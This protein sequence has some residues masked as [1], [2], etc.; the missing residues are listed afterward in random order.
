MSFTLRDKDFIKAKDIFFQVL[1]Y[2]HPNDKVVAIPRYRIASFP[3]IWRNHQYYARIF[4]TYSSSELKKI[5]EKIKEFFKYDPLLD[6]TLPLID[7]KDIKEIYLTNK[8]KNYIKKY[9]SLVNRFIELLEIFKENINLIYDDFGLT[10]S[11]LIGIHNPIYS[12]I[13]IV[14]YGFKNTDKIKEFVVSSEEIIKVESSI[15][16]GLDKNSFGLILK[17][18]WNKFKYKGRIFSIN[19]VRK[20]EE[21][22]L[23]YGDLIIKN[24]KEIKIRLKIIEKIDPYFYPLR[25][26]IKTED[27]IEELTI[28]EQYYF[29]SLEEGDELEILGLLQKVIEKN[30]E[31]LRVAYGVREI[32]NQYL[33]ILNYNR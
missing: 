25:Y 31:Y 33:R 23:K 8:W 14:V 18:K 29:D 10:G 26:K 1:G 15:I 22:T 3:T 28:F 2:I 20:Y 11:L 6:T 24:I 12:D 4:S 13:D 17:R 7:I 21:I 5:E 9:D 30:K 19:P 27:N 16:E 32:K